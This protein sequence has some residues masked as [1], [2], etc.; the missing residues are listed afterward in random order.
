[1]LTMVSNVDTELHIL[2]GS[3]L[4]LRVIRWLVPDQTVSEPSLGRPVLEFLGLNT[5]DIL[6]AAAE[7]HSGVGKCLKKSLEF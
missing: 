6:A 5:R 2:R 3:A 1:M 4:T 7:K